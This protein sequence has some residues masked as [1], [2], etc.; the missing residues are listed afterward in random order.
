MAREL[1]ALGARIHHIHA[2]GSLESHAEAP[3]R[4]LAMFSMQEA[5]LF[6]TREEVPDDAYARQ[7]QRIA[8][9]DEDP[10]ALAAEDA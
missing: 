6:R 7:E 2:D 1:E 10:R 8:Y 3:G 5:D 4:L 9:V